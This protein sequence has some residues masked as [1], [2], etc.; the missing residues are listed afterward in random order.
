MTVIEKALQDLL[1]AELLGA[2]CGVGGD[3][4]VA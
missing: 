2:S 3:R 4:G 1:L